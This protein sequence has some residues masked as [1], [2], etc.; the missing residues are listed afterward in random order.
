MYKKLRQI[1]GPTYNLK[2]LNYADNKFANRTKLYVGNISSQATEEE[3][4]SLF[5]HYG[6]I[7]QTYLNKKKNFA[8]VKMDYFLNAKNA[9]CALNDY[10]MKVK[11][12]SFREE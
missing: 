2:P 8:C 4:K 9:K 3:I 5:E 12:R 11:I 6:E 10:L 1:S 7:G